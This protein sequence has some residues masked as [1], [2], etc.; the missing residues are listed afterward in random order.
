[1]N[2]VT[3]IDR[4]LDTFSRY[5]DSGFGLLHG[6]VAFLTATLIDRKST[7]LNSSHLVI[8]Y[9]VFCL[10]KKIRRMRLC[11]SAPGGSIGDHVQAVGPA[12]DRPLAG[13]PQ[14]RRY[15][16]PPHMSRARPPAAIKCHAA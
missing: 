6:E 9:A 12:R 16:G 15:R 1:M 5:I 2:D 13:V 3:I 10:K 4:F 11:G 8:S 14:Q 7:R